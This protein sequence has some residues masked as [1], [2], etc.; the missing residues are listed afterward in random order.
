MEI[1]SGGVW[2]QADQPLAENGSIELISVAQVGAHSRPK[3]RF[4]A[5]LMTMVIHHVFN[6]GDLEPSVPFCDRAWVIGS[7]LV[8]GVRRTHRRLPSM[9]IAFRHRR[10]RVKQ[11]RGPWKMVRQQPQQGANFFL[12]QVHEHTGGLKENLTSSAGTDLIDPVLFKDR[13]GDSRRTTLVCQS[14]MT[15]K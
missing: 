8:D 7:P 6:V 3:S 10:T 4:Q 15:K 11:Q 1:E 2:Q 14:S 13:T 5:P 9:R 12:R